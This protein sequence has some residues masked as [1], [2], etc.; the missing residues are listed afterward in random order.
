MGTIGGRKSTK[1]CA[2]AE[3]AVVLAEAAAVK[4]TPSLAALPALP[5]LLLLL[6]LPLLGEAQ[7]RCPKSPAAV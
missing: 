5:T 3:S 6:L 1:A 2:V 7:A 4:R